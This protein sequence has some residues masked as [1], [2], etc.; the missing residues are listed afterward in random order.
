MSGLYKI[1]VKHP[2]LTA[3]LLKTLHGLTGLATLAGG[4]YGLYRLLKN[5]ENEDQK[6]RGLLQPGRPSADARR[7]RKAVMRSAM[8]ASAPLVKPPGYIIGQKYKP[9]EPKHETDQFPVGLN[10]M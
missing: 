7:H 3:G 1:I 2:K 6:G 10:I 5:K 9:T 8:L 4:T